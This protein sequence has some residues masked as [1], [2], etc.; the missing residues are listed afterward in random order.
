MPWP[1]M[2][3]NPVASHSRRTCV[4]IGLCGVVCVQGG[5]GGLCVSAASR[6]RLTG[7]ASLGR[8]DAHLLDERSVR[9]LALQDS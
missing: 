1:V 3:R 9:L 5:K 7:V 8:P 2:A 6:G 4:F